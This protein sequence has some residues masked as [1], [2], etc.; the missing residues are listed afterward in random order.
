MVGMV[1]CIT[2]PVSLVW[3]VLF[4]SAWSISTI[5]FFSVWISS[6]LNLPGP[7][8]I[9][10]PEI[11]LNKPTG[12]AEP[13]QSVMTNTPGCTTLEAY[14]ITF[15][16]VMQLSEERLWMM[17]HHC[18]RW[19]E[20][21]ISIAIHTK[22]KLLDVVNDMVG[23]GCSQKHIIINVMYEY[24]DYPIN[25]LRNLAIS[26]I[27]TTHCLYVDVDFWPSKDLYTTLSMQIVRDTLVEDD[28]LALVIPAFQITR[29][30]PGCENSNSSECDA[31]NAARMAKDR[32]S[33]YKLIRSRDAHMFDPTNPRGHHSTGYREWITQQQLRDIDCIESNR[34]EP[35]LAFRFCGDI[36][37]FQERFAGYGKN[38]LTWAM[39]M[40]RV[41][42]RFKVRI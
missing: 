20:H 33:L 18:E 1:K 38:K 15:T 35:Y 39:H 12:G 37:P 3:M 42:Y 16:L 9:S 11:A 36:P 24:G 32:L 13:F 6:D 25:H 27:Q 8:S 14:E 22:R 40:R 34:Y 26:S 5:G 31:L 7:I 41:G 28:K 21:P 30:G 4:L 17:K 29:K 10:N 23:M 2:R 19:G